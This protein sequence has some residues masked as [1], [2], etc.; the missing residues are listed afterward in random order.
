MATVRLRIPG[1]FVEEFGE[2]EALGYRRMRVSWRCSS[3]HMVN[4]AHGVDKRRRNP[5]RFS[6]RYQLTMPLLKSQEGTSPFEP[7]LG[8]TR[9]YILV[10]SCTF[11]NL[12]I[13]YP[14][15]RHSN[16]VYAVFLIFSFTEPQS[17]GSFRFRV[18]RA[19]LRHLCRQDKPTARIFKILKENQNGFA[20]HP[21][22]KSTAI[23]RAFL[24]SKKK[25]FKQNSSKLHRSHVLGPRL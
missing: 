16:V 4:M 13:R 17:L 19:H 25:N 22:R 12:Y 8:E 18:L 5:L 21:S 1:S 10:H 2:P 9:P 6:S 14:D 7:R 24:F 23:G 20:A 15:L 3:R 11:H